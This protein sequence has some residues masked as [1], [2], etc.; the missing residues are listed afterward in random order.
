MRL[1][2]RHLDDFF[3]AL[4]Y[5]TLPE[6][7]RLTV[8]DTALLTSSQQVIVAGNAQFITDEEITFQPPRYVVIE[9]GAPR[10]HI[11][12]LQRAC[13]VCKAPPMLVN[14]S[15]FIDP[16]W[17]A[18]QAANA[19][20]ADSQA[21]AD[22][23]ILTGLSDAQRPD[24]SALYT[25][26][27]VRTEAEKPKRLDALVTC[28][29]WIA[30][31]QGNLVV[32]APAGLG[33]SELAAV[34][35]W[36]AAIGYLSRSNRAGFE[37]LPPLAIR[38]Q[39]RELPTLSLDAIANYLRVRGMER[40]KNREVL[41]QLLLHN[42]IA[43]LLDGLDELSIPRPLMEEG[44]AEINFFAQ[45]GA[46]VLIT[47][48]SGYYGSEG[49]IRA[50]LGHE[51]IYVLEPL[52]EERGAEL[53]T[54]R[55]ASK[56]EARRAIASLPHQLRGVPLF[57]IWAWR[58]RFKGEGVTELGSGKARLLLDFVRLFCIRDEPRIKVPA[59]SQMTILKDV[60]YHSAFVG[61][62]SKQDLTYLVGEEDSPFIEGPHALLRLQDDREISFRDAT[63]ESLFLAEAVAKEWQAREGA[64]E[65][66]VKAWL[67]DRLGVVKLESL[68]ADFLAELLTETEIRTAWGL[69]AQAPTRYQPYAR[70]NLLAIALARLR[71]TAE[72]KSAAERAAVLQAVLGSTDLSETVLLDLVIEMIDF[73]GW[74]LRG[75]EGRG[76]YIAFCSF[77]GAEFDAGL[78]GADLVSS[79]GLEAKV[80]EDEIL[81]RGVRRLGRVLGPW[82]NHAL[83]QHVLKPE[84]A[85]DTRGLDKEAMKILRAQGLA[86]LQTGKGGR[87]FWQLNDQARSALREFLTNPSV[88]SPSLT[89]LLL[90]LGRG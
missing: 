82:R 16:L 67:G 48:R 51:S 86:E 44:L 7:H 27:A 11:E 40:L 88:V 55:G 33:K 9:D 2:V 53:L 41:T 3:T 65:N 54:K 1:L 79:S 56:D 26:Q 31:G 12:R 63:F 32:L 81:R 43:L 60:A 78:N 35:E 76:A 47:S 74:N 87:K 49:A 89:D 34:L 68:T 61:V 6:E 64:G 15:R 71:E 17:Q 73:R 72:G 45:E 28:E 29:E 50:K 18:S 23:D 57:L 66:E 83:G 5:K 58:S 46:R 84:I 4:G 36:R 75:C 42:R 24:P 39:L 8:E 30:S 19:A 90:A 38:V 21:A 22:L 80:P 52:D 25:D 10:Q 77:E 20:Q 69:A 37:A 85:E 14:F 62:V 59:E 13:S 70:R